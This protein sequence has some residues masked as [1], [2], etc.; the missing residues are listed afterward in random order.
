MILFSNILYLYIVP[1]LKQYHSSKYIYIRERETT[2]PDGQA[3]YIYIIIERETTVPDGE[4]KDY[5]GMVRVI[6]STNYLVLVH[7]T[8]VQQAQQT[9]QSRDRVIDYTC[10][11]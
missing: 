1:Q 2:V 3:K 10:N 7:S 9:W 4:F 8:A 5:G 11:T 6:T